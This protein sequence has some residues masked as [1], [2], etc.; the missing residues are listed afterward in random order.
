MVNETDS[1]QATDAYLRTLLDRLRLTENLWLQMG[2][3]GGDQASF[4]RLA[5][6]VR[7][8]AHLARNHDDEAVDD[9]AKQMEHHINIAAT[10]RSA[11]QEQGRLIALINQLRR[12]LTGRE[13]G[14]AVTPVHAAAPTEL[15]VVAYSDNEQ[16]IAQFIDAGFRAHHLATVESAEA[17]LTQGTPLA[18]IIDMDFPDE[19]L[20]GLKLVAKIRAD[21]GL[22]APV[23]ILAERDAIELRLQAVQTGAAGYFTKPLDMPALLNKLQAQ[24]VPKT[25]K[26]GYRVLIVD[27]APTEADK[28]NMALAKKQIASYLLQQPLQ[29]LQELRDFK[30]NLLVLDLDLITTSGI[31]L[32]QMLRQHPLGENLPMILLSNHADLKHRLSY[33]DGE[34]DDLLSTPVHADYLSWCI[35]QRLRHRKLVRA[36]TQCPGQ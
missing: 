19:P 18:L 13:E 12:A 20:G 35:Q 26:D 2:N 34:N 7:E 17:A 27:E 25:E 23:F 6:L 5:N 30:P 4:A 32:Y 21:Q 24:L 8:I 29:V 9:L 33:L 28:L 11:S 31:E 15:L 36:P 10:A 3:T 22:Q 1:Q 14:S 16:L